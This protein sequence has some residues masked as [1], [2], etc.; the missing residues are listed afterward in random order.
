MAKMMM[1]GQPGIDSGSSTTAGRN[2]SSAHTQTRLRCPDRQTLEVFLAANAS[3]CRCFATLV[4]GNH[5]R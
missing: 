3:E 5:S 4:S 2:T 1:K